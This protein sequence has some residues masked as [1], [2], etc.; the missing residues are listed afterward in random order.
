MMTSPHGGKLAQIKT[1]PSSAERT[2]EF[3][4]SKKIIVSEETRVQIYNISTGVLSPFDGFMGKSDYESVI[5]EM[6]LDDQRGSRLGATKLHNMFLSGE[7]LPREYMRPEVS[8][9][10]LE[11]KKP[12]VE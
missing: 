2:K 12:F 9:I 6:R 1:G 3:L 4:E 10:I 11:S 8:Q 5:E 7:T